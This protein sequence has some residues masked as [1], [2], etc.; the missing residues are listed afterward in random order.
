MTK[1]QYFEMCEMMGNEPMESEIPVEYDDLLLDVQDALRVYSSLQ[2]NW[3]Y[4]GGSYIGKNIVGFSDIMKLFEVPLEDRKSM[5]E[6]ILH[7]DRIRGKQINDA[8]K[9]KQDKAP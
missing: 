1:D 6:L 8:V 5:Y 2:D 3:D 4:M 9:A 7:I